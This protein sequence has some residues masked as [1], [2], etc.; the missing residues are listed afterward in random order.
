MLWSPHACRAAPLVSS[1]PPPVFRRAAPLGSLRSATRLTGA[2]SLFDWYLCELAHVPELCVD[3]G[4]AFGRPGWAYFCPGASLW[5]PGGGP[6]G[7]W[8][9]QPRSRPCNKAPGPR[10]VISIIVS[11]AREPA[12][13]VGR[14]RQ[15]RGTMR[16]P[17]VAP[18]GP[19]S[20]PWAPWD[21]PMR[22][23]ALEL[24][25]ESYFFCAI[26]YGEFPRPKSA[27]D[28]PSTR[29]AALVG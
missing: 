5:A 20:P 28:A 7:W 3:P 6:K 8:A 11:Y 23:W 9:L 16:W 19:V 17:G 1:P 29:I 22:C 25:F 12:W 2:H 27:F 13:T 24:K 21:W 26:V 15:G 10:G 14:P 18:K 4:D